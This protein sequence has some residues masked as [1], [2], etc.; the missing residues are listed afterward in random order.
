MDEKLVIKAVKALQKHVLVEQQNNKSQLFD[1]GEFIYLQIALKKIPVHQRKGKPQP[2]TIPNRILP[3]DA[4]VCLLVKDPQ[5]TYKVAVEENDVDS[6]KKVIGLTKLR[7]N[8]KTFEKKR[9]LCASYDIFMCDEDLIRM[10]PK[11]LGKPFYSK[12]KQPVVLKR[13]T[14]ENLK[15]KVEE[16]LNK[17]YMFVGYG[18]SLFI[19]IGRTDMEANEVSDNIVEGMKDIVKY[20]AKHKVSKRS[21]RPDY[22]I[23]FNTLDNV[24][25]IHIKTSNSIALPIFNSLP[26]V[27]EGDEGD[28]DYQE[29]EEDDDIDLGDYEDYD[30][31][32][33]E[34]AD[35]FK[36]REFK[37]LTKSVLKKRK[38]NDNSQNKSNKKR[39]KANNDNDKQQSTPIKKKK[40]KKRASVDTYSPKLVKK[41]KKKMR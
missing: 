37:K 41:T 30:E 4:E 23:Q 14:T 40:T 13:L 28:D 16:S 19:K 10:I 1:D 15:S 2:I 38:R 18:H 34:E 6:V 8:Y 17:T 11:V 32:E 20:F 25:S 35:N 24:Q 29:E 39:K 36:D 27:G 22:N 26:E 12:K 7:K 33:E 9:N 31:E 3:E 5:K 21:D